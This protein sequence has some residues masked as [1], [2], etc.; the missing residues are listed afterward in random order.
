MK[1][2]PLIFVLVLSLALTALAVPT[3][4]VRAAETFVVDTQNDTND[5]NPGNCVCADSGGNC[6]LPAAIQEAN[7]CSGA[8]TI[9]LSHVAY[10]LEDRVFEITEE[11]Y[12]YNPFDTFITIS[13]GS[14][15]RLFV[16]NTGVKLTL[17][18]VKIN[19]SGGIESNGQLW[20]YD[21]SLEDNQPDTGEDGGAIWSGSSSGYLYIDHSWI[22]NNDA[23]TGG[24]G[25][26]IYS[27]S[28]TMLYNAFITG[29]SAVNGGG[30]YLAGGSQSLIYE[31]SISTNTATS[32]G[33]GVYVVAEGYGAS[34]SISGSHIAENDAQ[35]GGG[36]FATDTDIY[37]TNTSLIANHAT[38]NG[39][40]LLI[41][42]QGTY[43]KAYLI[44][45]TVGAN[46][47]ENHGG[48][49]YFGADTRGDLSNVTITQN[50][51]DW[52]ITGVGDGS[53]DGGGI[54][55]ASQ[56]LVVLRNSL[57]AEN[58]DRSLVAPPAYGDPD[59]DGSFESDGYNLIGNKTCTITAQTGDQ[60]GN[61]FSLV[62]PLLGDR[63]DNATP[64][65][66][67]Y[68]PILES[69]P[70]I[71]RGNPSGCVNSDDELITEDQLERARPQGMHCDIGAYES[72]FSLT[73]IYLPLVLR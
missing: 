16:V 30:I 23:G 3:Q 66:T 27:N 72:S 20:L 19:Y 32:S 54:A 71:D 28:P 1:I 46:A 31:S 5:A 49:L 40:G 4:P 10:Q 53:G 42:T 8:D 61:R 69:S 25:G 55:S 14:V 44:N 36:L 60:F 67:S 70:L 22:T 35:N 15:F 73:G 41:S 58:S 64:N 12:I 47:A 59:C 65:Y 63:V 13:N 21:C 29:N 48:G 37:L 26:G 56:H 6:S 57:V 34:H 51:A 9:R 52:S 33:G 43:P 50:T 7:A 45:V 2:K 39:G 62:D 38:S 68:Y 11:L 18:T 17:D 24:D